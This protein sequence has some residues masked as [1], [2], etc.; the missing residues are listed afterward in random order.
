[1]DVRLT[2]DLVRDWVTNRLEQLRRHDGDRG[3]VPGWVVVTGIT[4]ALA[5]AIG[6]IIV[7]KVTTKANTINLQ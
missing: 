5:L 2:I 3:D 7:N 4:V 6:L 1:M